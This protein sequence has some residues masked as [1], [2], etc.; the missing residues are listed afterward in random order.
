MSKKSEMLEMFRQS[1]FSLTS[2]Q[3]DQFDLFFDLIHRHN[4]S[5]DLTRLASFEDIVVKHF[6]DSVYIT[7][8][9]DLPS[10]LLDIGT[11]GGFPG[12][13]LKILLPPLKIILAEPRKKRAS[14]LELA[15]RELD[16]AD[17][18]VYPH[19]VTDKSF[20]EVGGSIT[21][22]FEPI[23]ET[24]A[25]TRHFLHYG[26]M[27]FFMKGPEADAD[28]KKISEENRRSFS[29]ESDLWYDLPGTQYSRRIIVY[30]KISAETRKTYFIL[31]DLTATAGTAVTS[32]QNKK[33]KELEKLSSADG[34][35]K[36]GSALVT[37]KK[38][39]KE[40]AARGRPPVAGLVL[41]DG[42]AEHDDAMNALIRNFEERGS[43][44][45][46]KKSLFNR[47]DPYG[48]NSPL[49]VVK[50]PE[51]GDWDLSAAPG[52]T[53]LIPFQD[54]AN[55]GSAIR[56]A[57]AF[58]VSRIVILKEGANPYHPKSVRASVGTVFGVDILKGP[59]L[60]GLRQALGKL[61]PLVVALDAGGEP[62][63]FF[64]FPERFILL[65]GIEGPGL[66]PELR[67]RSVSIP[68]SGAVESLNAASALSIALY[69]WRRRYSPSN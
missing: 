50:I 64:S 58:D 3:A 26:A 2:R 68:L 11:G 42:Y 43:L 32:A 20:F 16:L 59:S 47:L 44:M 37:G 17:V 45:V 10:P 55:V 36:T 38:I 8:Y 30:K 7:R 19:M 67:E 12:I 56:S 49:A 22:A 33:F 63:H 4:A 14:F 35:K 61:A 21:R 18:T 27:V 41:F 62:L 5:L 53:L 34:I 15:V 48:T 23:D 69:E 28:M 29:L 52:C 9:V 31:K 39:I 60:Y 54:P 1:G 66:P 13:P 6:I 51:P 57:A 25:R 46:L 65:P 24:L 40:I